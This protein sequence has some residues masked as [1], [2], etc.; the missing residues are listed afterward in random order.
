VATAFRARVR[1]PSEAQ[2]AVAAAVE[3]GLYE[4]LSGAAWPG[5]HQAYGGT[6]KIDGFAFLA[7]THSNPD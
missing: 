4:Y 7:K 6:A 5:S 2:A 3:G 1:T